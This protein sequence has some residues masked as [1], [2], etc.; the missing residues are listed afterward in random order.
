MKKEYKKP[1]LQAEKL[2][3]DTALAD[4]DTIYSPGE[5][6]YDEFPDE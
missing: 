5:D 3:A 1:L 4:V 2:F 6:I